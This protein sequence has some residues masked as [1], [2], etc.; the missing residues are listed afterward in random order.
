MT[1]QQLADILRA[2]GVQFR[3]NLSSVEEADVQR[4][5]ATAPASSDDGA[6]AARPSAPAAPTAE[7]APASAPREGQTAA[8]LTA[9]EEPVAPSATEEPVERPAAPSAPEE[10]VAEPAIV[11]TPEASEPAAAEAHTATEE[12]GPEAQ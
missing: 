3:G 6:D 7:T 2:A 4:V 9:T 5:L 12:A 1:T 8:T 11:A 10:P